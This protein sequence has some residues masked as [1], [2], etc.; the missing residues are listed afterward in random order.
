MA[1]LLATGVSSTISWSEVLQKRVQYDLPIDGFQA[2]MERL[3]LRLVDFTPHD[4]EIT[5]L[6]W[7][8]TRSFG[9]SLA[10]RACLALARRLR[11]PVFTADRQWGELD[12]GIDIRLIR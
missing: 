1:P 11:L 5:A 12:L 8:D 2:N 10:D 4:A 7:P 3:G 9:L 6:L